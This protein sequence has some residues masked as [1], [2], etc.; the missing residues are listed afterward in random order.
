MALHELTTNAVKYGAIGRKTDGCTFSWRV[1]GPRRWC[2]LDL[3]H[4]KESGVDISPT[5][6]MGRAGPATVGV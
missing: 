1:A 6:Q 4:W 2:A 5:A 3:R